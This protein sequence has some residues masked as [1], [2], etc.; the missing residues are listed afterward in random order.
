MK[1]G[2]PSRAALV[3][4]VAACFLGGASSFLPD[5]SRAPPREHRRAETEEGTE[6]APVPQVSW[7]DPLAA[8]VLRLKFTEPRF[9][10]PY[11]GEKRPGT[12]DCRGCGQPLFASDDK[13][14]SG[15]GWPA[16]MR[17]VSD[18]VISYNKEWDGRVEAVCSQCKGHQGHVF[19][20]GPSKFKGGTGMR[21]CINGAALKFD[22]KADKGTPST[23]ENGQ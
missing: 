9:S 2:S 21:F 23:T 1:T 7:K 14:D 4:C 18:S 8:A 22:P 3:G 12:Y 15:C 16:F 17:P 10:S 20:D 13:F 19:P 5:H 11:N 6:S